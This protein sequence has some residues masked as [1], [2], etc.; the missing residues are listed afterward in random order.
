MFGKF[1][2]GIMNS[3]LTE[4]IQSAGQLNWRPYLFRFLLPI[5]AV[6]AVLVGWVV[7]EPSEEFVDPYPMS[8]MEQHTPFRYIGSFNRDFN[9]LNDL[10][11]GAALKH[12]IVPADTREDI[13]YVSGLKEI[14][15]TPIYKVERLTHSVPF[16]VPEMERL[17][18]E[19]GL[20]FVARLERDRLPVYRPIVTSVTRTEEDIKSLRR[21]NVNASENSCHRYGTTI[22]ISWKRFDKVDPKDPRSLSED[23]LKH[24]LASVLKTFHDEGR[25][26]IKH[27]RK[28]ACFHITVR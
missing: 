4:I 2:F 27:E 12:G 23:E 17:L 24:L 21:G 18:E 10:H 8:A 5:I 14:S 19:I 13:K 16:V 7:Y 22:D 1:V 15:T 3:F 26:Y 9:D 11:M 20:A 25:C 6:T 28:Q